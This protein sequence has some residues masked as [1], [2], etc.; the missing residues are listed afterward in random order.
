MKL[1]KWRLKGVEE[2][3]GK[4]YRGKAGVDGYVNGR[5]YK[6]QFIVPSESGGG[7]Y[8]VTQYADG[9]FEHYQKS[10]LNNQ[11]QPEWACACIGWT[12]HF[13]RQDCKH[14]MYAQSGGATTFEEAIANKLLGKTLD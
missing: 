6:H 7:D 3:N 13:P 2:L 10:M 9:P 11:G 8:V 4:P 12:R 5:P 14:I 1:P